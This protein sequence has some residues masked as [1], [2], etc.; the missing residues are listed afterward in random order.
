MQ[1]AILRA[2]LPLLAGWTGR[3]RSQAAAYRGALEGGSVA[4]PVERDPGHV[5][6][7]FVV[8]HPRPN[9]LKSHLASQGIETLVHYPVPVPEQPA[10]AGTQP[11]FCPRAAAACGEI[12]SLPLNAE[13]GDRQIAEIAA[14]VRR[15]EKE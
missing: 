14:A 3:R 4:P 10:F 2:R 15:F 1:A 8:R 9:A 12:L 5:Y 7:L 13:I 11:A 6:H